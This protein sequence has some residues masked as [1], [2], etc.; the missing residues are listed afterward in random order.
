[1]RPSFI[2]SQFSALCSSAI[3][4][5]VQIVA[6]AGRVCLGKGFLVELLEVIRMVCLIFCTLTK[7]AVDLR[8]GFIPLVVVSGLGEQGC[9]SAGISSSK[10][11][12]VI[13]SVG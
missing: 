7:M 9:F 12:F 2:Q 6:A 8:E 11:L 13:M 1:M 3:W 10:S 5:L 4:S